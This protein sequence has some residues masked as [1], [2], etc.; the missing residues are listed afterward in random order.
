MILV[1]IFYLNIR[2]FLKLNDKILFINKIK[3]KILS[4]KPSIFPSIIN[5]D[6]YNKAF[7]YAVGNNNQIEKYKDESLGFN[8]SKKYNE[9]ILL[10]SRWYR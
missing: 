7:S 9:D 5:C 1:K 8:Y 3:L 4:N 10:I 2:T 6:N